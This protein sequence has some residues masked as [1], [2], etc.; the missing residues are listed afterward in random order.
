MEYEEKRY[1]CRSIVKGSGEGEAIVS[2]EAMCFYLCDPET[3]TVIEKNH[4]LQGRSIAGKVLVLQSGKGSSVVQVDGFYQLSVKETLPAAIVVRETEPV[5]VSSAVVVG[6]PMVDRVEADPFEII[7]DG[8]WV[9]VDG[10]AQ[11]ILVRRPR[12]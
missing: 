10:E 4:P 6:E 5:L 3:G 1:R 12:V 8:D 9:R 11:E 7:R 2:R